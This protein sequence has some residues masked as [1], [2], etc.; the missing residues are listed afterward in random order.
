MAGNSSGGGGNSGGGGGNSGGDD[1][2]SGDSDGH[3][4]D[5][6]AVSLLV[7]ML[8][9]TATGLILLRFELAQMPKTHRKGQHRQQACGMP[10]DYLTPSHA[11]LWCAGCDWHG[12]QNS[13]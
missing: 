9:L 7:L 12:C 5:G 1:G 6:S 2:S 3:F 8:G 13:L 10:F 11:Q 4:G